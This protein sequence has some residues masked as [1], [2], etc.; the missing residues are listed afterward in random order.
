MVHQRGLLK[1]QP[2]LCYA[3]TT[4]TTPNMTIS[5]AERSSIMLHSF[6]SSDP[7][8]IRISL[9]PETRTF[10]CTIGWNN[11]I[12]KLELKWSHTGERKFSGLPVPMIFE[13]FG[14]NFACPSDLKPFEENFIWSNTL[15]SWTSN[16]L[17]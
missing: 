9:Q 4:T 11:E 2:S 13:K 14:V 7:L 16:S 10:L 15:P 5:S 1:R 17:K 6:T 3:V 12:Q 8:L